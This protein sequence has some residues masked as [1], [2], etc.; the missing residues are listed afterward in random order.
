VE[1]IRDEKAGGVEVEVDNSVIVLE[2]KD[3]LGSPQ[4]LIFSTPQRP[5]VSQ[6]D[7][8]EIRFF[9]PASGGTEVGPFRVGEIFTYEGK[10]FAVVGR[11]G[12][13]IQLL[14]RSESGKGPFWV[15]AE[16]ELPGDP[17]KP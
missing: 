3:A 9:T 17:A 5:Q 7:V 10:D 11:E 16:A 12:K 1:K 14:N 13:K 4:K 6:W 8:G 15:P 2:R